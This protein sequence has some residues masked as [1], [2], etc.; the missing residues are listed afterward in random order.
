M[1]R[2]AGAL[3]VLAT[4][5]RACPALA[6]PL[7]LPGTR[8][9]LDLGPTWTP[10]NAPGLVAAFRDRGGLTLAITRA[11]IPNPDA[12]RRQTREA[13]AADIE[14]GL[15]AA[16]PGYRRTRRAVRDLAGVPALEL[17]ARRADGATLVLRILLFRTYALALAIE[18]PQRSDLARARSAAAS[19]TPG[20][21]PSP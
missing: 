1:T 12:W 21:G 11:P 4:A 19:F 14:R 10:S 13:Y 5:L 16:V 8:A 6:E 3:L 9:T 7:D 2:G 17:E 20:A 15:A 18:V